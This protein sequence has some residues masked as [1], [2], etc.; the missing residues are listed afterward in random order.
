MCVYRRA[1]FRRLQ[2]ERERAVRVECV[3]RDGERCAWCGEPLGDILDGHNVHIDP[4]EPRA[5]TGAPKRPRSAD[6]VRL[7]HAG[8]NRE[9]SDGGY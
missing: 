6:G 1:Y 3:E 9:R 4:I 5:I 8:C 7:L 2:A